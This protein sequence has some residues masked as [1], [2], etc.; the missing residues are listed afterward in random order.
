MLLCAQRKISFLV[1]SYCTQYSQST[2]DLLQLLTSPL[3]GAFDLKCPLLLS[4]FKNI[5][6]NGPN[7]RKRIVRISSHLLLNGGWK[8]L[9]TWVTF[10]DSEGREEKPEPGP[11][12]EPDP[13]GGARGR[14]RPLRGPLRGRSVD[15]HEQGAGESREGDAPY[16]P[17][18]GGRRRR[19][20][21]QRESDP[22]AELPDRR[23]RRVRH[24]GLAGDKT[25]PWATDPTDRKKNMRPDDPL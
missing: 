14:Q 16:R 3:A 10:R 21:R 9:R 5:A 23:R 7:L 25:T 11:G 15:D 8:E 24:K 1:F 2:R 13:S 19:G 22:V 20:W 6:F 12:L 4:V 17:E 18:H